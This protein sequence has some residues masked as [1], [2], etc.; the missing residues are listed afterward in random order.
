MKVEIFASGS[1]ANCYALTSAK[2]TVLLDC[3]LRS[4]ATLERLNYRLPDAILVTH[5]HCDHSQAAKDFLKR[6]VE[7][8][9]T[10]GTAQTLKLSR[11]KSKL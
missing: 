4:K 11:H 9:M 2:E 7:V 10:Q 6:G 1:A 5:E 8:F 3:G